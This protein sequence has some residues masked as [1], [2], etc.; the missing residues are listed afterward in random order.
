MNRPEISPETRRA[1][2]RLLLLMIIFALALSTTVLLWM[3][4]RQQY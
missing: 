2:R 3:I 1:N 4:S